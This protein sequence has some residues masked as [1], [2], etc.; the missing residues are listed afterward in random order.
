MTGLLLKGGRVLD[1]SRQIDRVLDVRVHAGRIVDVGSALTAEGEQVLDAGGAWVMPAFVDLR[2]VL[3][4]ERDVS[5]ALQGGY[6]AVLASPESAAVD[7][8]GLKVVRA[9]ALTR[10]LAGEELGE[11]PPGT[12][13][14]SNG[15]KPVPRAGVM[16]RALQY[17]RAA[18]V[19]VMVHAED[20][21]LVGDGLLGES[22]TAARLGLKGIPPSAEVAVVARDL[23]LLAEVGGRLHFAHLTCARSLELVR[24]A[25]QAGL[26]VTCDVSA[27]HLVFDASV[28]EAFSLTARV[29]PPL[30]TAQDVA[31]LR[32]ALADGHLDAVSSDHVRV[33]PLDQEHPFEQ[34]APGCAAYPLVA[35]RVA[36]TGLPPLRLA[37]VLSLTPARLLGLEPGLVSAGA[38]A[39]LVVFDPAAGAVR[40]TIIA[41][42][43]RYQT[44]RV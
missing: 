23:E 9:A 10:D 2:G 32:Q 20:P 44:E 33:D 22:V 13:C 8:R 29:W 31:A 30:R 42:E 26:G 25:R 35:A 5:L 39:D 19:L 16:R 40:Q 36:G 12:V 14:A 6:G 28:A 18:N 34:C 21:S 3:R 11:L 37:E 43:L 24:A 7:P 41:G 1:P 17:A 27:Q 15:F 38:R 4:D